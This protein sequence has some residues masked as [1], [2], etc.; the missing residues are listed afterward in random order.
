[1]NRFDFLQ[2]KHSFDSLTITQPIG[3]LPDLANAGRFINEIILDELSPVYEE[4]PPSKSVMNI[5]C[6]EKHLLKDIS[7]LCQIAWKYRFFSTAEELHQ[8]LSEN[9]WATGSKEASLRHANTLVKLSVGGADNGN[10]DIWNVATQEMRFE[11]SCDS[12]FST[13]GLMREDSNLSNLSSYF[14]MRMCLAVKNPT[15]LESTEEGKK[16]RKGL[17][18][19]LERWL[20]DIQL[21][22]DGNQVRLTGDPATDIGVRHFFLTV[23]QGSND[24]IS[25]KTVY[26]MLVKLHKMLSPALLGYNYGYGYDR[27]AERPVDKGS[28][29]DKIHVGIMSNHLQWH[30]VGRLVH[31]VFTN[32]GIANF[33]LTVISTVALDQADEISADFLRRADNV[34]VL[35][36]GVSEVSQLVLTG[37]ELDIL[38]FPDVN[39]DPTVTFLAYSRYCPVQIAFWGHPVSTHLD[40]IDYFITSDLFDND[41]GNQNWAAFKEQVIRLDSLSTNFETPPIPSTPQDQLYYRKLV[42]N[43]FGDDS[44]LYL[45]AQTIMKLH[46]SFD[47]VFRQILRQDKN[48]VLGLIGT[49]YQMLWSERVRRRIETHVG[50]EHANRIFFLEGQLEYKS[51]LDL[52]CSADVT[53][54]PF[55]FGG[56]VTILES[57]A[58]GVPVVSDGNKQ[59]VFNLAD[60]W[61]KKMGI[62]NDTDYAR[63]YVDRALLIIKR[64]ERETNKNDGKD[65]FSGLY[66]TIDSIKE[67]E[68]LIQKMS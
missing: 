56:G 60:G 46:P 13:N 44:R 17:S 18:Q 19:M 9:L 61:M 59:T 37:L 41:G 31:G 66:N 32:L 65:D 57:I 21:T 8:K 3:R 62:F 26:Q 25:D 27:V 5:V 10:D 11:K 6:N 52:V 48:A 58:C 50:E 23:Y 36:A 40:S 15:I 12:I 35:D 29:V 33:H 30:S 42:K 53:L 64:R 2:A 16:R 54:D 39:L 45:C 34:V 24:T 43:E 47:D 20:S 1:M 63:S 51:Y 4:T 55:P 38:F 28:T 7:T 67:F 68:M 14:V 49:K 22:E